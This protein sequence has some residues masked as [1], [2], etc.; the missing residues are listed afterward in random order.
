MPDARL[1]M[2]AL[3]E[4]TRSSASMKVRIGRAEAERTIELAAAQGASR[5]Q[6][7][8]IQEM[9]TNLTWSRFAGG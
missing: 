2:V 3:A 5:R 1:R 4:D 6:P 8:P 9:F 7:G